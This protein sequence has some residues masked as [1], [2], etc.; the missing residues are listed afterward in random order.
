MANS[1]VAID[2][3]VTID[4]RVQ[5]YSGTVATLTVERE[6]TVISDPVTFGDTNEGVARVLNANPAITD[7]GVIVRNIPTAFVSVVNSSTATLGIGGVF[8]GTGE[9]VKDYSTLTVFV[10]TDQASAADGLSLQYSSNNVN[11]DD[12]DEYTIAANVAK[13]ITVGPEGKFFRI[14]YTN[15]GVGQT[16]FRLQTIYHSVR[17]K[18]SSHRTADSE[19]IPENSDAELV[20]AIAQGDIQH[21][22]VDQGLSRPIKL[23]GKASSALPAAVADGDRVAAFFDTTGRLAVQD[24]TGSLTVDAPVATPV[25]VRLSD[26]AAFLPTGGGVEAGTFRV[27]IANDSTGLISVD[28]NAGSLT[29]DAP[30][31]TPV[32]TRTSDGAAFYELP[33]GQ[34]SNA[35]IAARGVFIAGQFDDTAPALP[36]EDQASAVRVSAQRSLYVQ[37][38]SGTADIGV[39]ATPLRI[40]PTGTTAQPVTDNAGSLTV[41]AVDLDIRNLVAATDIISAVGLLAHDAV[42][43][44][45]NNPSVA[46]MEAIAHG[47]NPTAVA[48]ADVTKWYASRAG[49]PFVIGG[50]PNIIT[51]RDNFTVA[52]TDIAL[53][54]IGA[55][56]KIVVTRISALADKANTVDVA[57]RV[58]FGAVN[59]PTGLGV[60][61]SHPG[62]A[63]GSG[64][65][66]GSGAGILGVGADGEDLRITSEVPTTGSIDIVTSY[67][68]IES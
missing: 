51:R 64:V 13:Y 43:T 11:W 29:V 12:N 18:P 35:A 66:E 32:A 4:K 10:F 1:T 50:H 63:A 21:D 34:G 38:R 49:V 52:N 46:G 16:I 30:V 2:E 26:G 48:A 41:D 47:T 3:P 5:T 58:G 40:D 67:Y 8:T 9:E 19:T 25:A 42:N 27:T 39:L 7:Y 59:T 54:T 57:V 23:G 61:L 20:V 68:T 62:I 24:G 28:D 55:G 37:L 31:V 17:T 15:G 14:V 60:V 56:L 6:A 33:V 36:A 22:S 65:V 45:S 53:V 44:A